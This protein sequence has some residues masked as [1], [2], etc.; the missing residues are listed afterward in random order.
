M[1][2]EV[3]VDRLY[4]FYSIDVDIPLWYPK[5]LK[6]SKIRFSYTRTHHLTCL[7]NLYRRSGMVSVVFFI[8]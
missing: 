6:S 4:Y 3:S 7:V 1:L 2:R 8:F 5:D